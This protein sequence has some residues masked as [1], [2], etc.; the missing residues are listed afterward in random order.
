M[1]RAVCDDKIDEN[2]KCRPVQRS[3]VLRFE[4]LLPF[5]I[6]SSLAVLLSLMPR[7]SIVASSYQ[8]QSNKFRAHAP[9]HKYWRRKRIRRLYYLIASIPR[10]ICHMQAAWSEWEWDKRF[11]TR[12]TIYITNKSTLTAPAKTIVVQYHT[13]CKHYATND[14][15]YGVDIFVYLL[16]QRIK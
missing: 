11:S 4:H 2:G 14:D 10:R 13:K 5:A 8:S 1:G 16:M 12:R 7:L 3:C 15:M 6:Y 9:N